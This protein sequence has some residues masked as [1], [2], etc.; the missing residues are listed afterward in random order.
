MQKYGQKF[1]LTQKRKKTSNDAV[2]VSKRSTASA[3]PLGGTS[4]EGD[5]NSGGKGFEGKEE[6][7]RTAASASQEMVGMKEAAK[8]TTKPKK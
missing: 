8:E 5:L 2:R 7:T 3:Q 4:G 1:P 6:H